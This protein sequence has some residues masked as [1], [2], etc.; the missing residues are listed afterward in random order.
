MEKSKFIIMSDW[1]ATILFI[2]T[3]LKPVI[4]QTRRNASCLALLLNFIELML[5]E[6]MADWFP[7]A[8]VA[9]LVFSFELN[10]AA[11]AAAAVALFVWHVGITPNER[12][13]G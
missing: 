11:A 9:G 1:P 7:G 2:L 4:W 10:G 12:P 6:S 5:D 8:A 13:Y 3:W